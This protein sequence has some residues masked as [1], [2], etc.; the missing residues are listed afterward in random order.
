MEIV[1]E[2]DRSREKLPFYARVG[3]RKLLLVDRGPW[4]MNLY[5]LREDRLMPVGRSTLKNPDILASA[6]LPLSFGLV[7]GESRPK[8]ALVHEDGIARWVL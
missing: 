8:I 7:P 1:S 2:F 3:V 5:R 6:V 4:V